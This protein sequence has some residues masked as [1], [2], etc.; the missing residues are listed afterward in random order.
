MTSD[1]S[2]PFDHVGGLALAPAL[3]EQ[4]QISG[5]LSPTRRG[6]QPIALRHITRVPPRDYN[7][8]KGSDKPNAIFSFWLK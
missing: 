8:S 7:G 6:C 1:V 3:S 2:L 4:Q 5:I